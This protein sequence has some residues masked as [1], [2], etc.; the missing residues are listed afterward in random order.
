MGYLV[1]FI[2]T[3]KSACCNFFLFF[4]P[5]AIF[6]NNAA[7]TMQLNHPLLLTTPPHTDYRFSHPTHLIPLNKRAILLTHPSKKPT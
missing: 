4:R 5:F 7:H 3:Y 1:E 6:F 2:Y